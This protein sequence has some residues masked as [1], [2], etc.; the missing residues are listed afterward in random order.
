MVVKCERL[1]LLKQYQRAWF[2]DSREESFRISLPEPM[3]L[4]D[5]GNLNIQHADGY[6]LTWLVKTGKVHNCSQVLNGVVVK[7]GSQV[8]IGMLVKY[9]SVVG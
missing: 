6:L 1:E 2:Q 7:Y 9:C 8:F 3:S 4:L 5:H